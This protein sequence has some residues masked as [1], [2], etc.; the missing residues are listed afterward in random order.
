MEEEGGIGEKRREGKQCRRGGD[1]RG[2][3]GERCGEGSRRE[4]ICM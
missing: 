3:E 4:K 2:E 1:E